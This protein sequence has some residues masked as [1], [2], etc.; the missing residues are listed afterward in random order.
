MTSLRIQSIVLTCEW[1]D[2]P[3]HPING[4]AKTMRFCSKPCHDNARRKP[5]R[6]MAPEDLAWLAGLFDGEGSISI[7]TKLGPRSRGVKIH[8]TNTHRPLVDEVQRV[9]GVGY[10][11]TRYHDDPN[12]KPTHDWHTTGGNA[13]LILTLLIPRLIAKKSRAIEATSGKN[14]LKSCLDG[15]SRHQ[16]DH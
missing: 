4:R 10:I 3:F 11:T 6:R 13:Q 12:H 15:I 16:V 5:L 8:V 1:C 14:R 2:K 9:T 7:D